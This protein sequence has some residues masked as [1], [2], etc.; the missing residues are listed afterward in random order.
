MGTQ[1]ATK[2][3][4]TR[5]VMETGSQRDTQDGKGRPD[6]FHWWAIW[7]I[8]GVL[9]RGGIKYGR[10][11]S[12]VPLE[13]ALEWFT[14]GCVCGHNSVAQPAT[15]NDATPP[16]DFA[17]PATKPNIQECSQQTATQTEYGTP[18]GCV[19][20]AMSESCAPPTPTTPTNSGETTSVGTLPTSNGPQVARSNGPR[21]M[22]TDSGDLADSVNKPWLPTDSP[23]KMNSASSQTRVGGAPCVVEHQHQGGSGSTLTMTTP[24][25]PSAASSVD[26]ATRELASWEIAQQALNEHSPTCLVRQEFSVQP[27]SDGAVTVISET[28]NNWRKG[29]KFTRYFASAMRHLVLWFLRF[30]D[31]DH[32]AQAAWNILCIMEHECEGR[33]DLDDRRPDSPD[34]MTWLPMMLGEQREVVAQMRRDRAAREAAAA[35]TAAKP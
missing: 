17:F 7:R 14:K 20:P 28:A 27:A 33:T 4:G 35:A 5:E 13:V 8:W 32:L 29:Q 12:I 6:L 22:K 3:S 18:E 26:P 19:S 30:T 2:D 23:S 21:E 11:T 9:E 25:E 34:A 1:Y 31:E 10:S 24:P 15:Q 16:R